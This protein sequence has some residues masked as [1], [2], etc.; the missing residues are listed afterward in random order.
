MI[1]GFM[2]TETKSYMSK[3]L[4][5]ADITDHNN[6]SDDLLSKLR[7]PGTADQFTLTRH[8][9]ILA[10]HLDLTPIQTRNEITLFRVAFQHDKAL[11]HIVAKDFKAYLMYVLRWRCRG[12][13]LRQAARIIVLDADRRKKWV[14]SQRKHWKK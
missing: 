7:V 2:L 1:L 11:V 10:D 13:T 4:Y 6:I 5:M 9:H 3:P 8:V 12:L 14:S